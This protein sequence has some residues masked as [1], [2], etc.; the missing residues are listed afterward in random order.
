MKWKRLLVSMGLIGSVACVAPLSVIAASS[1]EIQAQIESYMEDLEASEAK[2][3][4]LEE[5]ISSKQEEVGG[6]C[7][8]VTA[9][10][11]EKEDYYQE[12]KTRIAYFYE[13][14]QGSSLL[15]TLLGS[16]SF[17][18]LLNRIQFQQSLYDYD[19]TRLE[20]Y[21]AL[22]DDLEEKQ[23]Q[24]DAEIEELGDMVEEQ[25]V[26]QAT[27]NATISAKQTEYDEAVAAEEAAAAAAK[28]AAEAEAK[29]RAESDALAYALTPQTSGSTSSDSAQSE[30]GS[31][32]S[33]S[34]GSSSSESQ[35]SSSSESQ[36]SSS[37]ESQGSSSSASQESSSSESQSSSSSG[38]SS[39][40]STSSSSSGAVAESG[41]TSGG[42][43]TKEKGVV[44]YNG[45]M[46]TWYSTNQGA[47][48]VVNGIPGRYTGS[49]GIIRDG[50]GY[51]CVASD[52]Y[53]KGTIIETSLGLG[54]V[55]DTGPG[56]GIVDIYT[57]W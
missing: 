49:D 45:H 29:R 35:G 46:E 41:Y 54:K 44:Y 48:G 25:A 38:G 2:S 21:Q 16:K 34:Q 26:L 19:A 17:A 28:A 50:D 37:S 24:L 55:Y 43:L 14:A 57:E 5:E 40:G 1:S 32:S 6:L 33:G 51:I 3:E 36:S 27:L 11:I 9:L 4:D 20:E 22:V 31:S 13:E 56:S 52:D 15:A 18:E 12:M 39:S 47:W 23:A 7:A 42:Q 8:E 53:P 10:N 30:S